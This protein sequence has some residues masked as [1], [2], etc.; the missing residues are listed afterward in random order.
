MGRLAALF[1]VLGGT[2]H[3]VPGAGAARAARLVL[4]CAGGVRPRFLTLRLLSARSAGSVRGLCL[5]VI[6]EDGTD[7]K[8]VVACLALTG[9]SRKKK[10]RSTVA[11]S[12]E[13][14][15]INVPMALSVFRDEKQVFIMLIACLLAESM[16]RCLL[17]CLCR[18]TVTLHLGQGNRN[19]HEHYRVVLD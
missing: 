16:Q 19:E 1:G 12:F 14:D 9:R 6:E 18:P 7:Q 4:S 2:P 15:E 13:E 3:R 11:A 8:C 5:T 17:F 10:K